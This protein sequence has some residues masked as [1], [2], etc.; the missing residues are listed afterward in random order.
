LTIGAKFAPGL[1]QAGIDE[2]PQGKRGIV[3]CTAILRRAM[4]LLCTDGVERLRGVFAAL[5]N[6]RF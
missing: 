6:Y 4:R 1:A 2:D 3:R 5:L